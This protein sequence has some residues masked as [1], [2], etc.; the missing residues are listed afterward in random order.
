M[1]LTFRDEKVQLWLERVRHR[2][3][4]LHLDAIEI[5]KYLKHVEYWGPGKIIVLL[6]SSLFVV[7]KSYEKEFE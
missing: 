4:E 6:Q 3:R 2:S 7:W 1:I 5:V